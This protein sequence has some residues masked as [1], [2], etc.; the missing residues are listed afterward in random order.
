MSLMYSLSADQINNFR[1]GCLFEERKSTVLS[2][3]FSLD[4]KYYIAANRSDQILWYDCLRGSEKNLVNSHKYGVELVKYTHGKTAVLHTSKKVNYDLRLLDVEQQNYYKYYTGHTRKVTSLTT[5][6]D[7]DIFASGSQDGTVRIWD[8]REDK[9][10]GKIGVNTDNPHVEFDPSGLFFL[11]GFDNETIY[12]YDM[13][14]YKREKFFRKICLEKEGNLTAH[15][16]KYSR[17]GT[18]LLVSTTGSK[19]ML[20]DPNNGIH[21]GNLRGKLLLP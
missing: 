13:R 21:L 10:V 12:M 9:C 20:F 14:S 19:I 16:F 5:S 2:T 15:S 11:I 4:G 17:D 1:E 3:D 7:E 8:F 18:K 6:A